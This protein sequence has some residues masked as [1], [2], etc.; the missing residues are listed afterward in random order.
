MR[1]NQ[2]FGDPFSESIPPIHR[3]AA[4][5]RQCYK[6]KASMNQ[7]HSPFRFHEN[8]YDWPI[9]SLFPTVEPYFE[10]SGFHP[11]SGERFFLN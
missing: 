10:G 9:R 8:E 1:D 6:L 2:T 5:H 4:V 11:H 3:V 7:Q